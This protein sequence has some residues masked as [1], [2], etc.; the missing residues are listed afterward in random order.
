MHVTVSPRPPAGAEIR[1]QQCMALARTDKRSVVRMK[2]DLRM[3]QLTSLDA[4][5]HGHRKVQENRAATA[6]HVS[7]N[8]NTTT[9]KE[10]L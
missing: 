4:R 1:Q 7:L 6:V 5:L 2:D 3:R 9:R 10:T 8:R